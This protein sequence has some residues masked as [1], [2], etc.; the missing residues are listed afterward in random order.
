MRGITQAAGYLPVASV[1]GRRTAAR[2]EDG[3]TLAATALERLDDASPGTTGVH[4][5]LLVGDL[6]PS[7]ESDLIRFLGSA[8]GATRLP[9]GAAGLR[10][11]I[12][13]ATDPNLGSEPVLVV[14]VDLWQTKSSARK[15]GRRAPPDCAVAFRVAP[16]PKQKRRWEPPGA[17]GDASS[18]TSALRRLALERGPAERGQWVGDF[19]PDSEV[20]QSAGGGFGARPKMP[21]AG[22]FSQG[23][24]VPQPRYVEN[25]PSRWRMMGET[26]SA[27]G[28]VT[29]PPRG[30]CRQC[31]TV[32]GLRS[33]RLARDGGEVV[34]STVIRSGGQP[35]EFDDQVEATGPYEVV[36]VE[37]APGVRVTLQVSDA[38]PGQLGIGARVAT[39]L[40]RLYAMEGEWRYGRKAVPFNPQKRSAQ[41]GTPRRAA[42]R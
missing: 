39:R 21:L 30:R 41:R 27:C 9:R 18:S 38:A 11:A 16:D 26:C 23:A 20:G 42:A 19:D 22:P 13:T 1:D 14:A 8:T 25:L 33:V 34:A 28:T 36:L 40:R 37:I 4:R 31:G 15:N 17:S 12:R 29:F 10:A 5:L 24:Y 32:D 35:T 2:D 6:P 3:F 7:A